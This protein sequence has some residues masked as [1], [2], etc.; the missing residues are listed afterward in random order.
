MRPWF[1]IP[2]FVAGCTVNQGRHVAPALPETDATVEGRVICD[3]ENADALESWHKYVVEGSV[4]DPAAS[5]H[6]GALRITSDSSAG[7]FWHKAEIDPAREPFL[8][9]RWRVSETWGTSTPLAPEFDNFPARFLVGFDASWQNAGPAADTFRKKV[10]EYAGVEPPARAICYTF[11]GK[12]GSNEAV[13]AAFGEGRIVVINLRGEASGWQWQTRDIAADY[14]AIWGEAAPRVVALAAG[15]D[16]HRVKKLVWAEFDDIT[17]FPASAA[18]QL[19]GEVENAPSERSVP[20][21]V[22]WIIG[23]CTAVAGGA[24]GWW[25]W[26]RGDRSRPTPR[27]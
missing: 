18:A 22:W 17:A 24:T 23:L 1:L 14:Q 5:T 16:S 15:S 11:G 19:R 27:V 25:I 20:P 26:R 10:R 4:H 9:W 13:D 8:R 21:V 12:L 2:A 3:F 6:E 7:L